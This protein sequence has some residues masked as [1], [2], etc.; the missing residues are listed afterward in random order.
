L[1]LLSR[2]D[3]S[4]RTERRLWSLHRFFGSSAAADRRIQRTIA[5]AAV[6][7]W[8]AAEPKRMRTLP[9][10]LLSLFVLGILAI[11]VGWAAGIPTFDEFDTAEAFNGPAAFPQIRS[12]AQKKF[13]AQIRR[14]STLPANFAGHY[15]IA[16]WGC[17]SSC[18]SIAVINLKTGEVHDGPFSTLGY[19][20]A[21]T[22]EGGFEE[23]EYKASSRM[24]VARGCPEDRNCGTCYFEWNGNRFERL[25]FASMPPHR[26]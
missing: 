9:L 25:R 6:V 18:V 12:L 16:A 4:R 17:G 5:L 23:L 1:S 26:P 7:I 20:S 10:S 22:C 24:L 21:Y 13:E 8:G 3:C 19:G 11:G 2:Q 15:K 14:Q